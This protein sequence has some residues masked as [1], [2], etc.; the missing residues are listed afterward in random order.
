MI[1]TKCKISNSELITAAKCFLND[2]ESTA[3]MTEEDCEFML[4]LINSAFDDDEGEYD[5]EYDYEEIHSCYEL[6]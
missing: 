4:G 5:E 1:I 6:Y 3:I 2:I